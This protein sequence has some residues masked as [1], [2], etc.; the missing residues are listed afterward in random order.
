MKFKLDSWP[1][2]ATANTAG[3]SNYLVERQSLSSK[4]PH[5]SA[6]LKSLESPSEPSNNNKNEDPS[7]PHIVLS[8]EQ[9]IVLKRVKEGRNVFFTGSAG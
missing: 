4:P 3:V 5:P 1:L 8:P 9:N 2:I 7:T 6:S